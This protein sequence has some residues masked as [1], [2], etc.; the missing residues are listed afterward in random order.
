MIVI[1][2]MQ[3]GTSAPAM[4]RIAS[5][6]TLALQALPPALITCIPSASE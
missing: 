3:G 6:G 2:A 4:Q 1:S 5:H